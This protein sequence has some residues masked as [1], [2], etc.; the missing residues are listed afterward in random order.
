MI[1]QNYWKENDM[2][3]K[4]EV[5]EYVRTKN[6]LIGTLI[7]ISEVGSGVRYEGEFITDEIFSIYTKPYTEVCIRLKDRDIAKHSKNIIDLIEVG[8][9]VELADVLS[10]EVIYIYDEEMLEAI[11]QDI[12]E[13]Q[14]LKSIA[15][16]E[17]FESIKYEV[18]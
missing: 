7:K 4:I 9:I 6:G 16:K 18:M 15:T 17:Q 10:Q 1:I 8:D 3:D 2:E 13:G 5:G 14:I 11:K 12:E